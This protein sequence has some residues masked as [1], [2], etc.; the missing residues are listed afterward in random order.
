MRF[1]KQV[2]SVVILLILIRRIVKRKMQMEIHMELGQV[3]I[4]GRQTQQELLLGDSL[5]PE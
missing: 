3:L 4:L 1:A 5:E 2:V